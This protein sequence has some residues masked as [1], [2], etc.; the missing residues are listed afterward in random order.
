VI[1]LNCTRLVPVAG[2]LLA[3]HQRSRGGGRGNRCAAI[4]CLFV[5]ERTDRECFDAMQLLWSIQLDNL[6]GFVPSVQKNQSRKLSKLWRGPFRIVARR[7]PVLF[8]LL[9]PRQRRVLKQ[10]VHV[11][12]LKP[13]VS[14][15]DEP[16]SPATIVDTSDLFD[17]DVEND[18]S[19]LRDLDNELPDGS[20]SAVTPLDSRPASKAG[21]SANN[22]KG[23]VSRAVHAPLLVDPVR[24]SPI[25]AS[26]SDAT[27]SR[28]TH[29]TPSVPSQPTYSTGPLPEFSE[30]ALDVAPHVS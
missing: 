14:R 30:V 7:G 20:D 16:S 25:V 6:C 12:R 2:G 4:L 9:V 10:W 26:P 18:L 11:Q 8:K 27:D 15:F 21:R 28:H 17:P 22:T 3:Y 1:Y 24:P 19:G 13:Y 29:T 5:R 23:K